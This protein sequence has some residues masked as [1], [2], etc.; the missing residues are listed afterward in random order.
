MLKILRNEILS[1]RIYSITRN[2]TR[3]GRDKTRIEV[4]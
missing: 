2:E 1:Y 4:V 3:N